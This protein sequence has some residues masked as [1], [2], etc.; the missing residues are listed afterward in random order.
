MICL[1]DSLP[2]IFTEIEIPTDPIS[3]EAVAWLLLY[4]AKGEQ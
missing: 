4:Y 1:P 2:S 3:T